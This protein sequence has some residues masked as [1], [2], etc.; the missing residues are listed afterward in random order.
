MATNRLL[1]YNAAILAMGERQLTSISE[2]REPKRVLDVVWDCGAIDFVLEQGLWN[3][4][5][6][7]VRIDYS[8]SV[9]PDFGYSRAFDKPTDWIRTAGFSLDEF[10]ATPLNQYTDE[11]GFWFADADQIYV[12]Y[13]SNDASYGSDLSLWPQTFVKYV[14]AYLAWEAAGRLSQS[15]EKLARLEKLMKARLRDARSKDGMNQPAA[16]PP[17][18][19]WSRA[20]GGGGRG[21]P[22][23]DGGATGGLIG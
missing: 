3:F 17:R 21:G 22:M 15:E 12:R 13:V 7:T 5:M 9:E 10:F 11:A 23:G 4:A 16:F 6:R 14:A 8:P 2:N 18:G 1:L 19:S 20:R